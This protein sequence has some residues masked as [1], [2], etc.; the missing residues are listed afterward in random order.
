MSAYNGAVHA[1]VLVGLV[2]GV[3][4]PCASKVAYV[5][6]AA[7]SA[8]QTVLM[9]SSGVVVSEPAATAS[10]DRHTLD[11]GM[12]GPLTSA[13]PTTLAKVERAVRSL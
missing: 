6:Y 8:S 10:T 7:E 13:V 4:V 5:L 11:G 12:P 3:R 9:L 1:R 2:T